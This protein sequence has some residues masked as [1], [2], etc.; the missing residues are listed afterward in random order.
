MYHYVRPVKNSQYPNINGL[1]E[2]YFYNQI[3]FFSENYKILSYEEMKFIIKTKKIPKTPSFFLT[4]DDGYMDHYKYV[5][6]YLVKKKISASFY[7][8]INAIENKIVLDVN[9]IHF[10]LE[11]VKNHKKVLREI[12]NYLIKSN[13][14]PLS[15][16]NLSKINLVDSYDN[17]ETVL[18]KRL[19]QFYFPLKLREN[20]CNFLF[21]KFLNKDL[22]DFSKELYMNKKQILEM[23]KYKMNFGSHGVNHFWWKYL[24]K[25]K[26]EKEI[27]ESLNYFKKINVD[28]ENFSVCYPY[29]SY[30]LNTISLL[31]KY[32]VKFALTTKVGDVNIKNLNKN[33]AF[34][35]FDTNDF[36]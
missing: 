12:D 20:I 24:N 36:R 34:P 22:R 15:K 18:V 30:N 14:K 2:K 26:Q 5:F 1:E 23:N 6:P 27:K 8:P 9:K 31:K 4:F 7:P 11:K 33:F 25:Y 29:G 21:K 19:L 17:K 28:T 10:I 35:R 3:K 13:L 32:K 16:H